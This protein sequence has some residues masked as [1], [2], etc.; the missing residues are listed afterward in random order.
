MIADDDSLRHCSIPTVSPV[1]RPSS[2]AV[3]PVGRQTWAAFDMV[4][5]VTG[6]VG[7]GKDAPAEGPPV[8][9]RHRMPVL[10]DGTS[11]FVGSRLCRSLDALGV[12]VHSMTRN[13]GSYRSSGEAV[14]GDIADADS[15]AVALD[16]V[17]SAY[18]LVHSLDSLGFAE[19]DRA[20]AD[21]FAAAAAA[22]TAG[23]NQVIY[24]G[25][26]GDSGDNL[27]PHLRSRREVESILSIGCRR[28]CRGRAS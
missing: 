7:S 15:L 6:M 18:Y 14:F 10:V 11:G 26:L 20:G 8:D 23:V 5:H 21:R 22:A 19:R 28:R 13:P 3:E 24:L 4:S 27:S 12:A 9:D 2:A 25:G 17:D 1:L 16:G